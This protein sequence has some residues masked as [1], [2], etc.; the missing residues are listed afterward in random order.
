MTEKPM[1]FLDHLEE[2]RRT[3]IKSF[4][5]VIIGTAICLTF[6]AQIFRLLQ[7][8]LQNILP[9]NSHFITTTPFE[10][11]AAYLKVAFVFGILLS[12][13]FIFFM[14]WSFIRPGLKKEER[15]GVMPLALSCSFLFVGGALFGYFFV[16]PAGFQFA[17]DILKGSNI[18][19]MPRMSDYLSFSLRM[20]L[21]FG[22]I[23]ELPL[24]LL[25]LGK[26][27]IVDATKLRKSRKYMIVLIFLVA[28][29]LTPGP[30]VLSQVLMAAPLLVLFEVG[31][32]LVKIFGNRK[33]EDEE[34]LEAA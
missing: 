20:L 19:F 6:S 11:Y 22:L 10:S 24:F 7:A 28:G 16:F 34:N 1:T 30:D 33:V 5:A 12:S 27:G 26:F 9:T 15:R 4:V 2:F 32:I 29:I 23:F 13:P 17:V 8:P 25:L 3:V 18:V 31:I 14:I 21:A